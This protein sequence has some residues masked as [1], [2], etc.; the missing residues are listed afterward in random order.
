MERHA[1]ASRPHRRRIIPRLPHAE[2][3]DLRSPEQPVSESPSKAQPSV[4]KPQPL[5]VICDIAALPQLERQPNHLAAVLGGTQSLHTNSMDETLALP[6]EHAVKIARPVVNRVKQARADHFGSDCPMA[7]H[8]IENG[9]D[10]AKQPEHPL[11][12]L[13]LAYGI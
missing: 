10:N 11:K 13:R 1:A 8:Q 5:C 3:G 9:L 2:P 4:S 7:G 12:L 6:S